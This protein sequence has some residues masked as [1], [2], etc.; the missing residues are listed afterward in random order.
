MLKIKRI[1]IVLVIICVVMVIALIALMQYLNYD[2]ID[3]IPYE[4]LI[5]SNV[6]IDKTVQTVNNRNNYYIVK[7]CVERFYTYY[8]EMF[9]DPL[10]GY[11][12]K[13]E[14]GTVDTEKLKKESIEKVYSA[15]DEEY[16]QYKGITLDNVSTKL[17]K[18][19][20][21]SIHIKN[22]YVVEKTE[23]I[24]AYFVYGTLKENS[25][26]NN[27][28]MMIKLDRKN[29][30]YKVLLGDYLEEHYKDIKINET[31]EFNSN[32]EIQKNNYNSIN[33]EHISDEEYINDLFT[34]YK[35]SLRQNRENTYSLVEETY[36]QKCFDNQEEYLKYLDENYTK[37]I[38][39]KLEGYNKNKNGSYTEY[40]FKDSKENYYIFR[41]TAPFQYTVMLDNYVIPT[42]DFTEEYNRSSE[43]EK[44]ILNIK[45]FFM[46]IDDK[47]YGYSYSMLSESFKSSKYSSKTEFINYVKQN[48]F[49]QNEIEYI[50]YKKENGLY[51]YEIKVKDATGSS[52]DEKAFNMIVKLKNGTDFEMS[53]G[54]N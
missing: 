47:N 1:I 5:D 25:K 22:M 19:G 11:L 48:F 39:A 52:T 38:T 35:N 34:H 3:N 7:G 49:E 24:S 54:T 53:F 6:E 27:F 50:K 8:N 9:E 41:E 29:N 13:P 12:I 51:I 4:E 31:L 26:Y 42:E 30:T 16:I 10:E 23:T 44:V 21:V 40:L 15:L 36:K 45:K 28:S 14:Q 20:D 43:V 37:I 18:I 32:E 33:Y 17:S 2:S 46:G